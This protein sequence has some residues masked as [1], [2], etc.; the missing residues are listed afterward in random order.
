MTDHIVPLPGTTVVGLVW[1]A[2]C[3]CAIAGL[4]TMLSRSADAQVEVGRPYARA[5]ALATCGIALTEIGG[6]GRLRGGVLLAVGLTLLLA[7]GRPRIRP[8]NA[9]G[10]ARRCR[11]TF[12]RLSSMIDGTSPRTARPRSRWPA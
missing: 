4:L 3:L 7:G 8:L 12:H 5:T 10:D 1:A 11:S 9:A 2:T 6:G